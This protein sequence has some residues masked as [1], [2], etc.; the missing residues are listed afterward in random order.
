MV[1]GDAVVGQPGA[2]VE[3]A[4]GLVVLG[5]LTVRGGL[6]L[7]GSLHARSLSVAAPTRVA[8]SVNWRRL[9]LPGATLPVV[10]ERG[11]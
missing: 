4:G 3:L 5:R 2:P 11:D 8:I 9:P 10:V 1:D 7:A 6:D